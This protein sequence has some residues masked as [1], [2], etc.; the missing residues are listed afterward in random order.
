M[1]NLREEL[2]IELPRAKGAYLAEAPASIWTDPNWVLEVKAD[3]TRESLQIGAE[4]SLLVGRNRQ[5]KLKGV[6]AAGPFMVHQHPILDEVCHHELSGTIL[7]GELTMHFVKEG[8]FDENTL[9]RAA[10]GQFVGYQVW[11]VLFFQGRDVRCLDE[12]ER[13]ALARMVVNTLAH[14]KIRMLE[15][16]PATRANLQAIWDRGEEGAIAKYLPGMIPTNQRTCPTWYKLKT[17]KTVDAFVIGV[18][19]GKEGGSGVKG[20]KAAPNG[21]AAS[22]TMGMYRDGKIVEVCKLKHLPDDIAEAG[23]REFDRFNNQVIE[24][25]VS[26][27]DGRFCR[28]P[29]FK[30]FRPDKTPWECRFEEQVGSKEAA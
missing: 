5:D 9:K 4:R 15:R 25:N 20:V 26:G 6:A 27:W 16:V 17:E 3:G 19:Q 30:K 28:W 8:V 10:C 18:T 14:P 7:D 13:Y 29:R 22:F 23:F 21:K 24:M 12:G 1:R 11:G 2:N